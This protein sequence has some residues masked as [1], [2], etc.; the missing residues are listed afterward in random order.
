MGNSQPHYFVS[1]ALFIVSICVL[2]PT[3]W[4]LSDVKEKSSATSFEALLEK[5]L[6]QHPELKAFEKEE[7]AAKK[8]S[9]ESF[10]L[11]DTSVSI[12]RTGTETPIGNGV[13]A[14]TE[15]GIVQNFTWPGKSQRLEKLALIDV[16]RSNLELKR[17]RRQLERQTA[18][19]YS[20]V[21]SISL[22]A[23][24]QLEKLSTLNA[25]KR[26]TSRNVRSGFG[27]SVDDSLIEREIEITRLQLD[28]LAF[29]QTQK[30]TEIETL[31]PYAK[32]DISVEKHDSIPRSYFKEK[33]HEASN[34]AIQSASLDMNR[35][36]AELRFSKQL[37]WPDFNLGLLRRNE[38]DYEVGVGFTIPLWYSFRQSKRIMSSTAL[39]E[40]S[41]LRFDYQKKIAPLAESLL[42]A[43]IKNIQSQLLAR[44]KIARNISEIAL[45]RSKT[46]FERGRIDWKQH[47]LTVNAQF[48]DQERLVDLDLDLFA[49]QLELYELAGV[50]E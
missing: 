22:K 20:Q 7:E 11:G 23:S 15:V 1:E 21:L 2:C 42:R 36:L 34:F 39:S 33:S 49:I 38:K 18:L 8:R 45:K 14:Q 3:S 28:Q 6:E 27:T 16:S 47:Q 13:G 32:I 46:L 30:V 17:K 41:A 19:F 31:L 10:W 5:T 50:V 24:I 44:E 40:A 29:D 37:V 4:G 35:S 12:T 43:K 9:E 25:A 48:E 26:I